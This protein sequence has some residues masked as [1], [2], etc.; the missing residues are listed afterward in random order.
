MGFGRPANAVSLSGTQYQLDKFLKHTAP[1]GQY[2]MNSV[3]GDPTF[4]AYGRYTV[5]TLASGWVHVDERNRVCMAWYAGSG[6]G[7]TYRN[8][9]FSAPAN[10]VQ[11]VF[12][13]D[14]FKVH[15]YP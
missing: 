8:G 2:D 10:C 6:I 7:I 1:S 9:A 3:F 12:H 13:D 15:A 14:Q 5:T 11:V 4:A